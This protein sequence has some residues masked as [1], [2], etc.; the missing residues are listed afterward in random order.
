MSEALYPAHTS[1]ESQCLGVH[2]RCRVGHVPQ[3]QSYVLLDHLSNYGCEA[4]SNQWS[5]SRDQHQ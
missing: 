4:P 2:H 3:V 1:V 5:H